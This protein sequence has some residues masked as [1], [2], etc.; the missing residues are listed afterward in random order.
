MIISLPRT[1]AKARLFE[2]VETVDPQYDMIDVGVQYEDG[3]IDSLAVGG[4]FTSLKRWY[5]DFDSNKDSDVKAVEIQEQIDADEHA[6]KADLPFVN[7]DG[8]DVPANE[9]RK[10][11]T[12]V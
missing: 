6:I 2:R 4:S 12:T 10:V 7:L 5:V 3:S 1:T 11:A 9:Q 8:T